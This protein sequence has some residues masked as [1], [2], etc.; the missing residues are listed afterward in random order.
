MAEPKLTL[1]SE[2]GDSAATFVFNGEDHTLGN[3][4][5][6]VLLRDPE[7]SF[8]GYT[9]PHPQESKMNVRIQTTGAPVCEV[10]KRNLEVLKGLCG[11]MEEMFVKAEDEAKSAPEESTM[12]T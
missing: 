12:E 7:V 9:V 4:L 2:I 3:A 5:R 1:E 8:C 10:L 6:Y 11:H